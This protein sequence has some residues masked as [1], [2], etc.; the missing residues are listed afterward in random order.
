[1]IH[2]EIIRPD[3]QSLQNFIRFP[4][5]LYK[6]DTNWVP[7]LKGDLLKQL[8]GKKNEKF[9]ESIQRFF[10][11]YNDNVPIARL[12][13]GIDLRQNALTGENCGWFSLFESIDSMDGVRAV[14][15]AA[16]AFMREHG[17]TRIHGPFPPDYDLLNRGLLINGFDSPPVLHNAYHKPYYTKLFEQYGLTRKRTI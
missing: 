9:S 12:L 8:N 15:D 10:I 4:F 7:P 6:G 13:A 2:V 14:M 11:A 1:M 17:V 3:A 16:I 5:E